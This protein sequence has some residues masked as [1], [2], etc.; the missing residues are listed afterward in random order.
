MPDTMP[1]EFDIFDFE[2][3]ASP[4]E[5][6]A[7][8]ARGDDDVLVR[9]ERAT[10]EQFREE[11]R[12]TIDGV[13]VKVPRATPLTDALGNPRR[14]PDGLP[15]PRSTTIYDAATQL[16]REGKWAP[17]DLAERVPVLCHQ[18]H[19]TPVAVCRMCSVHI[20]SVKRGKLTPGRK[21]VPACQHRVEENMAVTT[22]MGQGD[23]AKV[24]QLST[25]V[26]AEMLTG[27][28]LRPDPS[29]DD[30]FRNELSAVG[31]TVGA[32]GSRFAREG[33]SRNFKLHEKS[34]P[35]AEGSKAPAMGGRHSLPMADL[36]EPTLP[37]SS[38]TIQVDHDRCILCDRCVRSCAEVKPFSVIGHTGKGFWT[39]ISFDLDQVMNQS[40][41]VQCGECM[42]ACPTG[43]L[44]LNRR[45]VPRQLW[46][47]VGADRP[48]D[49]R[50]QELADPSVALPPSFLTAEEMLEVGVPY[51]D[52]A[53]NATRFY[54]FR[55]VPFPY[56]RWNEGAVRARTVRP[57]EVLCSQ[58]EFG[59]TA[60]ILLDGEFDVWVTSPAASSSKTFISRLLG[61]SLATGGAI[62]VYT[63]TASRDL[64]LGEMACL[65][66]TARTATITGAGV[67]TVLELSRNMLTMLQRNKSAREVLDRV[68]RPRA[69]GNCLQKGK[70]FAGLTPEQRQ[71]LVKELSK[72]A[73]LVAVEPGQA[74]VRQ[75]DPI[76][77][78]ED[79]TFRGDFYVLRLGSA[80]VSRT[81][82]GREQVFAQLKPDDSFGEIALM[83]DHP[84]VAPLVPEENR[85]RRTANVTALD[86][87]EVVRIPGEEFR[88]LLRRYPEIE[89]QFATKCAESLKQ[90]RKAPKPGTDLLGTYLREGLFQGQKM[91][92]LDLERCTRCDEC[93]RACADSHGDG[94]SRLLREGPR[95]GQ[96]LVATACRSCHAPYCMDGCPVDAIHRGTT[97][98]E[99]RIDDHCI[100][101]GL[102]STNCPYESI[103]MVPRDGDVEKA[104]RIAAVALKAVNCDLCQDLVPEKADPFCVAA[105]PHDAAF[106]WDGDQLLQKASR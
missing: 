40:S 56:L 7:L 96:Y 52:D 19:L 53:G 2:I 58:G 35:F 89:E 99:V 64:I 63:A 98:L 82:G 6:E 12:I 104:R 70:L 29:R 61:K 55:G 88:K 14:G 28:H 30:R 37:Y 71:T 16:V 10:R 50:A 31:L 62:K 68:Y 66:N 22:R 75:G 69:I 20:S 23:F 26:L 32:I 13:E 65:T 11:I 8:F 36:L 86:D 24:V 47:A 83:G 18:E 91:L 102:C 105:C 76:G 33:N 72:V 5:E 51:F 97:S 43:A 45:V 84:N 101:C 85:R 17:E 87:V 4:R 60:F 79:G 93:T 59:T 100:G 106:R 103:Q 95:F 46:E 39:R 25:Q 48:D 34:R 73:E 49:P 81:D 77:R 74:I 67:G 54:P 44:T 42:T 92:V 1:A 21:L 80:K 90:Q 3:G 78:S 38:R 41:C 15:I 57:D 94:H 27:D 9:Q